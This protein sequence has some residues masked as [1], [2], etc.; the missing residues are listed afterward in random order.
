M[1]ERIAITKRVNA[2]ARR[3]RLGLPP[4]A[5]NAEC[6]AEEARLRPP[7]PAPERMAQV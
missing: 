4:A 2:E 7:T 6:D 1:L 5:T 3:Q